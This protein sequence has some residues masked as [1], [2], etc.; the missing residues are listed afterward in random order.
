[1]DALLTTRTLIDHE[2]PVFTFDDGPSE[3]TP[4]ILDL[5]RAC[6]QRAMFFLTGQYVRANAE[7]IR[8][9]YAEGH[10]IG[11]HGWSHR[12][13]TTLTDEESRAEIVQTQTE[14]RAV[15]GVAPRVWRAPFFDAGERELATAK[16]LGLRHVEANLIPDDWM[17]TNP[18]ALA[19]G[20][21]AELRP[22]SVVSLHDGVPPDGGSQ[23]CTA[24]RE[25]TVEALRLVL[26]GM[27]G[28]D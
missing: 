11:N 12:R 24:S 1:M 8:R 9:A 21:L 4:L 16:G 10:R 25:V 23:R 18:E 22:G 6:N 26:E 3:W 2:A 19:I 14:I 15:L 17:A 27:G 7:T 20:I 5:L 28:R 13:L